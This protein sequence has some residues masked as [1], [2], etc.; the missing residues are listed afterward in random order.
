MR[1]L[2]MSKNGLCKVLA[3]N[4]ISSC[5]IRVQSVSR[6]TSEF[7]DNFGLLLG[8]GLLIFQHKQY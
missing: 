3:N 8:H 2:I 6:E 4:S 7:D 5:L 1:S